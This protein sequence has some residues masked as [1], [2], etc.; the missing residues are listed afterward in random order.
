MKLVSYIHDKNHY[1]PRAEMRAMRRAAGR[2]GVLVDNKIYSLQHVCDWAQH[3]HGVRFEGLPHTVQDFVELARPFRL[4]LA[5]LAPQL[6][7]SKLDYHSLEE[8]QLRAPLEMPPSVRDFYAFEQHVKTARANRGLGV[9]A[10]WY[11]IPVFYFT[12][13][14]AVYSPDDF[15]PVPRDCKAL[16]FELEMACVIGKAGR[17]IS[18]EDAPEYIAGYFIMNDW[19][20]RDLQA[21]EMAVGLGPAKGKDFATSFGPYLL[22]PDELEP[23]RLEGKELFD[24]NMV[25]RLNGKEVSRGNFSSIYYTFP[26]MIERAS[27]NVWLMPG[28]VIGSGTVGTGCLL[29]HGDKRERWLQSGDV[30]E[31]EIDLLG[32]LRNTIGE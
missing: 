19:S 30:V 18:A 32:V 25:A 20:A 27:A 15:V 13:H 10:E 29:E 2:G 21:P 24:L 8:V 11:Q 3:Q 26:Q 4:A 28:D 1:D 6:P 23:R 7:S 12:N 16:D 9:Q 5:D 17:D 14:R 22:T 31:L